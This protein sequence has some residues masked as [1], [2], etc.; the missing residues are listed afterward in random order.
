MFSYF[1]DDTYVMP[2]GTIP[3]HTSW[4]PSITLRDGFILV[5]FKA[6][7]MKYLSSCD[8]QLAAVLVV[9]LGILAFRYIRK[10]K[11]KKYVSYGLIYSEVL[12]RSSDPVFG[13]ANCFQTH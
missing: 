6:L 11:S 13:I 7:L 4:W 3:I 5:S 1:V 9:L 10:T 8:M 2:T 12:L